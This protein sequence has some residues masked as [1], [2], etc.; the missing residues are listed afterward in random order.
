MDIKN[1]GF[2]GE[3]GSRKT[4]TVERKVKL[5]GIVL[6]NFFAMRGEEIAKRVMGPCMFAKM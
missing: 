1:A 2:F 3:W 6:R 5:L 4:K